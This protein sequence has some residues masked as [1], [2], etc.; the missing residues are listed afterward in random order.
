[1]VEDGEHGV[2]AEAKRGWHLPESGQLKKYVTRKSFQETGGGV[3]SLVVLSECSVDYARHHLGP[4]ISGVEVVP[5]AWRDVVSAASEASAYASH[6]GK[7]LLRELVEYLKVTITMQTIESNLVYVVALGSGTP[8]GW[9]IS[10]ID[11][12][13]ER[14]KYFHPVGIKGWPHDPPNYIAF[15]YS[16]RLQSIHHIDEYEVITNPSKYIPEIPVSEWEPHYLYSPG[17]GFMPAERLPTGRIYPNGRVWCMLD[18]LFTCDTIKA[19]RDLTAQ[20]KSASE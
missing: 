14:R 16:G 12:V 6:A 7:R 4:E 2:K 11:I 8:E 13:K 15:R 1:M 9:G 10:W 20:R 5:V 19:A 3:R 18:T 17:A